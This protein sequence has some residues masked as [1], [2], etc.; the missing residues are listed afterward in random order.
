MTATRPASCHSSSQCMA[1]GCVLVY[2]SQSHSWLL[3]FKWR[4]AVE[5]GWTRPW[6]GPEV[7]AFRR[8]RAVSLLSVVG[9][10]SMV[11]SPVASRRMGSP[12]P[13]GT[14][15]ALGL[16]ITVGNT[17]VCLP[18]CVCTTCVLCLHR[19]EEGITSHGTG[20]T[21]NWEPSGGAQTKPEA[22]ARAA[23]VCNC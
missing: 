2:S 8:S 12:R 18:V 9:S 19:P 4:R 23:G 20:I 15:P 16:L 14:Q 17:W 22:S 3:V 11:L 6:L 13:K 21:V 7:R 10:R 1:G 5:G